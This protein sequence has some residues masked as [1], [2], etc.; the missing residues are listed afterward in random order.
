MANAP[1]IVV[2]VSRLLLMLMRLVVFALSLGLTII[3]FQSYRQRPSD[4]LE[5]A[6]IGFAFLSMG[7][8]LTA[9]RT[10]IDV[11]VSLFQIVETI[12]FIIGFGMLYRSLYR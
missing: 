7:V 10:Q 12:P 4:R 1:P 3:S 5:S 6:F 9:L 11:L 8:A 2:E